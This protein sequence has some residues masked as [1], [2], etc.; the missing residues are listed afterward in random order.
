MSRVAAEI[1]SCSYTYFCDWVIAQYGLFFLREW[2][3]ED[4]RKVVGF[5]GC[6]ALS[7]KHTG[8]EEFP[9]SVAWDV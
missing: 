7:I 4:V 6:W 2:K 3:E 1:D 8:M 5:W 9:T